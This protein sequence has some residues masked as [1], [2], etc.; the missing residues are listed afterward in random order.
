[1]VACDRGAKA[2]ASPV[3]PRAR[4]LYP[5]G[6]FIGFLPKHQETNSQRPPAPQ[7]WESVSQ[8]WESSCCREE[9]QQKKLDIP[10]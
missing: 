1:M 5:G 4:R 10:F 3:L 9:G 2:A 7:I 6:Q 8:S